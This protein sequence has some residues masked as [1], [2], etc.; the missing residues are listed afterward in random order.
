VRGMWSTV[1]SAADYRE[2]VE[3][4][5]G[6]GKGTK[7]GS[8]ISSWQERQYTGGRG[9]REKKMVLVVVRTVCHIE[10]K[11]Q[12]CTVVTAFVLLLSPRKRVGRAG[13]RG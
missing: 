12:F 1:I 9:A 2:R 11:L 10:I 5:E 3:G 13:P 4:R 6:Q 7:E 8:H